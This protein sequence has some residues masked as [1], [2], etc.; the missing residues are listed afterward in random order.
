MWGKPVVGESLGW[1]LVALAER[2]HLWSSADVDV[3]EEVLY[4]SER[5]GYLEFVDSPQNS[6]AML[7]FGEHF[8]DRSL[9]IDA[10]AHCV[11]MKDR[12][13]DNYGYEVR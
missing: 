9:W 5:I 2:I 7:H 13:E 1:A 6:L 11:G 4:Y 8:Q 12:L 10:Y 3:V